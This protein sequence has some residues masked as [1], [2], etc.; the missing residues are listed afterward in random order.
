VGE[1]GGFDPDLHPATPREL[2][3]H[4]FRTAEEAGI[5]EP[6]AMTVSTVD[7]DG[8]PDARVLILK[9]VTADG[10]WC[11][12]GRSD[13]RKGRQLSANPTAAVTFYWGELLR[14]VRL[15]GPITA[16]QA[17]H[18]VR[19]F[20]ARTTSARAIALSGRQSAPFQ[21]RS[22]LDKDLHE[23]RTRLAEDPETVPPEWTVW[24]LRPSSVEFWEGQ[25]D[26]VHAR[27]QYV[28]RDDGWSVERLRP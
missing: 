4:W 18:A 1:P 20:T 6:H 3:L 17:E 8:M 7:P 11:F 19:D 28:R 23:A 5:P 12:A 27:L 26:R 2:F 21:S 14:S 16:A 13:S 15:R 9:D 22:E 24:E 10:A 25:A